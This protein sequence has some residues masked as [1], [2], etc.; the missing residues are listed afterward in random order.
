[1]RETVETARLSQVLVLTT[2]I[3]KCYTGLHTGYSTD[4][5]L[6]KERFESLAQC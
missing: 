1:M 6:K 3:M 5:G 4:T 2:T